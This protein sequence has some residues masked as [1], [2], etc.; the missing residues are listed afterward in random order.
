MLEILEKAKI[1]T[2][3]NDWLQVNECLQQLSLAGDEPTPL[4]E[5]AL[6]LALT[7]LNYG[8]FQERWEIAKIL[9]KFGDRAIP[10]LIE[11]LEDEEIEIEER[12]FAGR[13]LGQFDRPLA[14]EALVR[15]WQ[16]SEDEELTVIIA[17]ALAN[18]G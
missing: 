8:D 3:H 18:L 2:Q 6:A 12:W 14:I 13:I 9:P 16:T 7:V 11:I 15:C 17:S 1:A 4:D 10:P 5:E